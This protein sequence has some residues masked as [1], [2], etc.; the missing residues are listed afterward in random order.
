MRRRPGVKQDSYVFLFPPEPPVAISG[1]SERRG[2]CKGVLLRGVAD[3]C[4]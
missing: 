4:T 3:P 1:K 2:V